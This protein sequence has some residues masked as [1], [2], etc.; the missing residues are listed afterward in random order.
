VTR[1][2][3]GRLLQAI[4][5]IFFI[6]TLVFLLVRLTGDPSAILVSDFAPVD[7]QDRIRERLGLDRSLLEQYGAYMGGLVRGDL[8]ESFNGRPVVDILAQYLPAT[9]SLAAVAMAVTLL[10][11]VP[12][13]ILSA[14]YRGTWIDTVARAVA[15]FGQSVPS[16]WLAIVLVLLFAVVLGLLPVAYRSGPESYILPAVAMGWA[17]VAGIVRLIR[18]SM[19]DVLDSDYVRMARAKG[20]PPRVVVVKHA[21]RSALIPVLT[22]TGLVLASF[23]NG[24]VVVESVFAWPGIGTMTLDAVSGR[25]FPVVQGA[26]IM[27]AVFFIVINLLVDILYAFVDPRIRYR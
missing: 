7:V 13:G 9:A 8:G 25:D 14:V 16:F 12:L 1:Y 22:F 20:M 6:T 5:G 27:I 11:A 24:S 23:M 21:L 15:L 18:S 19:L 2:I 3:F 26:V 4:V 10:V 17:A